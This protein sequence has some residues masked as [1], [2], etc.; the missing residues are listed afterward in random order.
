M[1]VIG[2]N[3]VMHEQ[4]VKTLDYQGLEDEPVSL[5]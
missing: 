3:G 4:I 5:G 1:Q 2:T